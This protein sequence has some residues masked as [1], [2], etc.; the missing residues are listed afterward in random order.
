VGHELNDLRNENERLRA[1]LAELR[2][3]APEDAKDYQGG[4]DLISISGTHGLKTS[5]TEWG[6]WEARTSWNEAHFGAAALY[7]QDH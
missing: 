7:R 3:S 4:N 2:L 5:I 6:T 1:D